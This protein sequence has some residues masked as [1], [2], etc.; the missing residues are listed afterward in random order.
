MTT[1]SLANQ[2][3]DVRFFV[4]CSFRKSI[5]KNARR[6]ICFPLISFMR[7]HFDKPTRAAAHDKEDRLAKIR[8]QQERWM[9]E[10]NESLA[11]PE[12]TLPDASF[13]A[14]KVET[15]NEMRPINV[16]IC[17]KCRKQADHPKSIVP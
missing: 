4:M 10:R 15:G 2:D 16:L 17:P 7:N 9:Q 1:F 11:I 5:V 6:D 8:R 12:P 14:I 3:L 13:D